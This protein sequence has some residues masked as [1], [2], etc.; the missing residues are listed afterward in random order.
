M[1]RNWSRDFSRGN[2]VY[3]LNMLASVMNDSVQERF[4]ELVG[5]DIRTIRVLRLIGDS[6]GITFA[7]I[8][9]RTALERS[10]TSRLIQNLVKGGLVE[11]RNFKTDARRFGLYIT[12]TGKAARARADHLTQIGLDLVFRKLGPDEIAAFVLTMEKLAEWIDSDEFERKMEKAFDSVTF[13]N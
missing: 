4:L 3:Q 8:T 1:I 10:L 13:G 11:R 5:F 2:P 12:E 9:D 7:E 6:P